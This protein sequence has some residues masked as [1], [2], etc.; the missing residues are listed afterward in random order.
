MPG[1]Q[2]TLGY[3]PTGHD[4]SLAIVGDQGVIAVAEEERYSRIKGGR[5]VTDPRWVFEVLAEFGVDAAAVTALA[6]PNVGGLHE[7]RR[8][9]SLTGVPV[10]AQS[11]LADALVDQVA[12][13]LPGLQSVQYIRHHQCHAASAYLSSPFGDAT[14]ITADGMGETESA[15]IWAA[16]GGRLEQLH[17]VPLPHSIGYVYQALAWWS[18]LAGVEREGKFMGLSSWG[19]PGHCDLLREHF[20]REDGELGFR[21]APGLERVPMSGAAWNAYT[22][23]LLGPRRD[24]SRDAVDQYAADIAASA[25]LIVQDMLLSYLGVARRL[26]AR[27]PLCAAGGV[28]MNT[29]ANGVIRQS[30]GFDGVWVQPM[31]G[32][33]GLAL[34]AALLGHGREHREAPRWVMRSA[35][36]GSPLRTPGPAAAAEAADPAIARA[37]ADLVLSGQVIGWAQGRCEVGA[38]AL[39]HRSVLADA[40]DPGSG[41]RINARLKGREKWRPFAPIVLAEDFERICPGT[42]PSDFMTFVVNFPDWARRRFPAVVHV[43]GTARVQTVG[44]A[45]H[46]MIREFLLRIRERTGFGI[47]LNTSLNGPGQPIARTEAD[48][49]GLFAASRLDYLVLGNAL[50]GRDAAG[51]ACPPRA[52]C[53]HGAIDVLVETCAPEPGDCVETHAGRV[54]RLGFARPSRPGGGL[55]ARTPPDVQPGERVV[56]LLPCWLELAPLAAP[57]LVQWLLD[58]QDSLG[59]PVEVTDARRAPTRLERLACSPRP[60]LG[61]FGSPLEEFWLGRSQ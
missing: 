54:A 21:V 30:A 44:A 45:A 46:P 43:D 31:A 35:A 26:G 14:V 36:L 22:V 18:G 40:R 7:R 29:V 6:V 60:G 59:R 32:D 4:P 3:L 50:R 39:G 13:R 24:G 9:D 49:L 5:F 15:T 1:D 27:G 48:V 53:A 34:G 17:S 56:V 41:E 23:G 10:H 16:S 51:L 11:R 8:A 57:R 47:A 33:N 2:V 52:G 19:R 42:P 37:A 61:G 55:T 58:W 25:Q 38:R 20:I 12:Q 28:F